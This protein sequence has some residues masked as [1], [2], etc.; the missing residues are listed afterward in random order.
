[1]KIIY[2][3]MV[4]MLLGAFSVVAAESVVL[5]TGTIY[6]SDGT[7]EVQGATI[8]AVCEHDSTTYDADTDTTSDT[9]GDY[10]L[11]F[12]GKPCTEDDMV[13]VTATKDGKSGSDS[14]VIKN[15]SAIGL[16]I[17]IINVSIPE[18]GTI[19]AG[20]ALLGGAA[21]HMWRRRKR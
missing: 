5:V 12:T 3:S 10:S 2:L 6:E 16:D 15:F 4:L 1:M 13:T 8:S 20:L 17:A 21:A 14:D 11:T 19:T 9:G 18:F 7:T